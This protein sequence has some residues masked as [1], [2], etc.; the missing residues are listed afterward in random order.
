MSTTDSATTPTLDTIA[1]VLARDDRVKVAGVD[2]DGVLRGKIV[3]KD[4]FLSSLTDGFGFCSV[5]FGWDLHD[6]A[7]NVPTR[8]A[9]DATGFADLLAKVDLN[10]FRRLPLEGNIPFFLVRFY[11]PKGEPL[12]VCPRGLLA[13]IVDNYH[14]LGLEPLCGAEFEFYNYKETPQS[15]AEK[16]GARIQPMTPGMFGYSLLRPLCEQPFF[17]GVFDTCQQMGVPLEGWHTESG[18]GVYEA[19]LQYSPALEMADRAVLFKTTAK[20]LGIRHGIVA[21]F[22]A[23]PNA[24]LPGCSGH[25]HFSLRDLR[26]GHNVFFDPRAGPCPTDDVDPYRLPGMSDTMTAFINGLLVGLPSIL[27][28]LAP[29][30]NSYKRLV[31]NYWAPVYVNWG[32]ENRVASLRVIGPTPPETTTTDKESSISSDTLQRLLTQGKSTRIEM[33][34]SGSDINTHLATAACLACGLWG[35][36]HQLHRLPVAALG[37]VNPAQGIVPTIVEYHESSPSSGDSLGAGQPR[38]TGRVDPTEPRGLRLSKNL[39]DAVKAM[40]APRS[41]ARITLGD[42]FVEHYAQTRMH[43]YQLWENAITDW[44]LK[45]YLEIL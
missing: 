16:Q 22:M 6:K 5:V 41:L 28:I 29:N 21:S 1:Q 9:N 2:I 37:N 20:Q 14:T 42:E 3:S 11:T 4:K 38:V 24:D 8:I 18:P 32:K 43:E 15:L 33:R 27:A 7:Y 23:K 35:I 40:V 17:Q 26:Q 25:L 13:R 45:R 30:V 44:E 36:R 10:T 12:A 31:E 34:V 39:A 19:A